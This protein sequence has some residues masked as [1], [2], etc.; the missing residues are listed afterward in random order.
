MVSAIF[1]QGSDANI[2]VNFAASRALVERVVRDLAAFGTVREGIA[3]MDVRPLTPEEATV[4][5]GVGVV[6]VMREGPAL[7]AGIEAGDIVTQIGDRP[8]TTPGEFRAALFRHAP[9]A[10]VRMT[11]RRGDTERQVTV[12]LAPLAP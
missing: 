9:D 12:T 10:G 5:A 6:A 4:T 2:G 8:V 11:V 7:T 1:A 3:G